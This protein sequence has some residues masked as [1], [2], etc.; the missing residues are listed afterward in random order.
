[1][2]KFFTLISLVSAFS[3]VGAW[4]DDTA[5]APEKKAAPAKTDKKVEITG[6]HLKRDVR[7]IGRTVDTPFPT[8]V[9]DR[10]EI[11]RSGAVSIAEVLRKQTFV[12][13]G[14]GH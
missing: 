12:T 11:D 7:R 5:T 2:K 14:F 8:I 9:I 1:M 13:Q 3:L 10:Q 4:A 6:S